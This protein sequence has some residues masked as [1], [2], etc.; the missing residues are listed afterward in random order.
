MRATIALHATD[1]DL[2]VRAGAAMLALRPQVLVRA[3]GTL[4]TFM[5]YLSVGAPPALYA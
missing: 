2:P 5:L 1:L 4:N 3:S